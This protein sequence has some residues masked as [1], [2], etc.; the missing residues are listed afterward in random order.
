M[1]IELD[2][3]VLPAQAKQYIMYRQSTGDM[4][5]TM[6]CNAGALKG[7]LFAEVLSQQQKDSC[8]LLVAAETAGARAST[9]AIY[10]AFEWPKSLHANY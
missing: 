6:C 5:W 4:H 1:G 8:S 9:F 2:L 10:A 3:H 7:C